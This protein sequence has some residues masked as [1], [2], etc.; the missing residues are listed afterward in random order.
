MS[1]STIKSM[2]HH[3]SIRS[4]LPN[5]PMPV[6]DVN[7]IIDATRKAPT[8][9]NGQGLTLIS[10]E[11]PELRKQVA[12]LSWDQ[13]QIVDCS[14]FLVF[15]MDLNKADIATKK[16]GKELVIHESIEGTMVSSV[17]IGIALGTAVAAAESMGYGTCCIG[18]IRQS[19]EEMIKLLNLPKH[20]FAVVVL[21]IGYTDESVPASIKPKM[22]VEAFVLTDTY[23]K[24]IIAKNIEIYDEIML[25]YFKERGEN[26]DK[27]WSGTIATLYSYVYYPDVHKVLMQQ[28]F[29]LNK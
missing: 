5:K 17:D 19:P 26:E 11:N 10:I 22:P 27:S 13:K 7:A 24:E 23:N 21:C 4:Y 2:I 9:I 1:N 18:A 3:K 25:K 29:K 12:K 8:S 28:G 16:Q 6:E 14:T 15:V 20:T